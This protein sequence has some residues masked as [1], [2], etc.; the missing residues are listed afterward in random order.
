MVGTELLCPYLD[1]ISTCKICYGTLKTSPSYSKRQGL[2]IPLTG[3]CSA[4]NQD[5][6]LLYSCKTGM[7]NLFLKI[8]TGPQSHQH[9]NK[10]FCSY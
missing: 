1:S 5:S 2:A 7:S 8:L 10:T 3:Y 6:F 4:C 9:S